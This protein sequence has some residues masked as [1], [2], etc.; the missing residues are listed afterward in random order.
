MPP[1]DTAPSH[2]PQANAGVRMVLLGKQGAGKG[3]QAKRLAN[4]YVVPHISTGDMFRAA[5]RDGSP[6]GL[7][8][9][10]YLDAGELVPD[11]VV[12]EVVRSR[13]GTRAGHRST[14]R[15]F[16]LDGFPRTVPQAEA[17]AAKLDELGRRLTAVLLI[18]A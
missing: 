6:L 5:T 12:V 1:A 2:G 14:S 11:G 9:K 18:D 15:G 10:A 8:V 3:T 7:K 4:Y 17:L 13:L 16:I